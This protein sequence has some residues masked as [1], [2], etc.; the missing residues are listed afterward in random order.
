MAC[1]NLRERIDRKPN[2]VLRG[3]WAALKSEEQFT[4]DMFWNN[5]GE[6]DQ[7][8]PGWVIIPQTEEGIFIPSKRLY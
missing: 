1:W 5:T 6:D 7:T 8:R 4:E 2:C 3:L